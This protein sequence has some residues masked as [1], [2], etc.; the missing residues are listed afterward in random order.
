MKI[1]ILVT[2]LLFVCGCGGFKMIVH[3]LGTDG[4]RIIELEGKGSAKVKF[5]PD[6][7]YAE[8]EANNRSQPFITKTIEKGAA[9]VLSREAGGVP[10]ED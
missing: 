6:G 4:T 1:I 3:P 10:V 9:L 7:T 5:N 8:V 2:C